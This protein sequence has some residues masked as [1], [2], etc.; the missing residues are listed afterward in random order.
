MAK[1]AM[2]KWLKLAGFIVVAGGVIYAVGQGNSARDTRITHTEDA[3]V[4]LSDTDKKFMDKLE[5][6]KGENSKE[7]IAI[8]ERMHR[9]EILYQQQIG[10]LKSLQ[11]EQIKQ[12]EKVNRIYD[13]VIR[14]EPDDGK[15]P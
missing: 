10:L 14:W 9:N 3:V 15:T 11:T 1:E 6:H 4:V 2:D 5:T 12:S 13:T 7:H 8:I